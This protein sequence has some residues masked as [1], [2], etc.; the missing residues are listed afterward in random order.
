MARIKLILLVSIFIAFCSCKSTTKKDNNKQSNET[1]ESANEIPDSIAITITLHDFFNWYDANFERLGKIK[2]VS[3]SAEHLTLNE[4]NLKAYLNEI[5]NSGFV[6]DLLLENELKFYGACGKIWKTQK[7]S[8]IPQGLQAD[9]FYCAQDYIAPYST[10]KVTAIIIQDKANATLSV[11][12]KLNETK[13]LLFELKKE[14][15]KWL[16]SKT[17]CNFGIVY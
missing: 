5:K 10:G 17:G 4:N 15:G 16:L 6:S 8:E 14:N 1:A 11:N 12:G 7:K 13:D 3:D 2:F 9:R